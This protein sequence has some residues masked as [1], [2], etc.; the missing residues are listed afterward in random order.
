ML[1]ETANRDTL[2]EQSPSRKVLNQIL[3]LL[4]ID[5]RKCVKTKKQQNTTCSCCG[6]IIIQ[7]YFWYV[8]DLSL[9][10]IKIATF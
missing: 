7:V 6:N 1:Q 8:H 5:F 9:H 3:I 2:I 10:K 4:G